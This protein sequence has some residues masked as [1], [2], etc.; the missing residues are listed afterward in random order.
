MEH[1]SKSMRP[2]KGGMAGKPCHSKEVTPPRPQKG[3]IKNVGHPQY[4][5]KSNRPTKPAC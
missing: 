4:E 2:T 1:E 5:S 3:S